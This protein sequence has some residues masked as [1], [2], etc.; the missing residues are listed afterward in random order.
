MGAG[1]PPDSLP[2]EP[3]GRGEL[4]GPTAPSV[5]LLLSPH[6]VTTMTLG[7]KVDDGLPELGH[8]FCWSKIKMKLCSNLTMNK[9]VSRAPRGRRP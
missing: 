5:S 3:M 9:K 2:A 1:A 6:T 4:V 7:L 8:Q